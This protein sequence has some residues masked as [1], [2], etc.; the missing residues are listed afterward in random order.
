MFCMI[1]K[2]THRM[3][4]RSNTSQITFS[5]SLTQLRY[6]DFRV[7]YEGVLYAFDVEIEFEATETIYVT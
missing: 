5:S 2:I 1:R 7:N 6:N 4:L 3:L